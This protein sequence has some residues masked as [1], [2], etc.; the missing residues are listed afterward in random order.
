VENI[1]KTAIKT[2]IKA[3][4]LGV[5]FYADL[6]KKF[7][8]DFDLNETFKLLARDEVEHKRQFEEILATVEENDIIPD[9]V[10]GVFLNGIDISAYFAGMEKIDTNL[11]P[12]QVLQSAFN[13][14][15]ESV[16]YYSTIRDIIGKNPQ[17]D[18]IIKIEKQHMN[19]LMKIL[20]SGSKFRGMSD[21]WV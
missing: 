6:A 5:V 3:E 18:Q 16:L 17:L 10:N 7:D 12:V 21:T 19:Q 9:E 13:F 4:S 8:N 14:E 1:L 11:T 15:K 20:A 2:A